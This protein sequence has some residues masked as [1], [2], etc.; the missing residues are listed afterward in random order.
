MT[1]LD[2]AWDRLWEA[3]PARWTVGRPSYDPGA[4]AWSISAV[5]PD[6]GR[7]KI[8]TSVSGRGDDELTA[9][10]DLD[11]RLRG[12]RS[13]G[14]R[15][16]EELRATMRLAYLEGAERWAR[17]ELGRGLSSDELAGVIGRFPGPDVH[18]LR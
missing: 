7:G 1:E 18:H 6:R 3:M 5:G 2:A 17:A 11:A 14:P 4:R 12:E 10:R 8:P 9:I 15:K 16:L 13:D